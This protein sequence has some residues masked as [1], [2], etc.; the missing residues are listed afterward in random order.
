[1]LFSRHTRRR[2]FIAGLGSTAA[3]PVVARAQ[4]A[5]MPTVGYLTAQSPEVEYK[6]VTI[7][8][9]QGL[10]EAGFVE[11]QNVA[12]AGRKINTIGFRRLQPISSSVV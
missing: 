1:M 10:N 3:W 9:L 7:P 12:T 5:A 8:F 4:Q 2:Q 6:L 11:G